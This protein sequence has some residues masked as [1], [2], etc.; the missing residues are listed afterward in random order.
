MIFFLT[1]RSWPCTPCD[2]SGA[3]LI[4][5]YGP[6]HT[7]LPRGIECELFVTLP[8]LH[9]SD[10]HKADYCRKVEWIC[11]RGFHPSGNKGIKPHSCSQRSDTREVK[12]GSI[13]T[14]LI[15]AEGWKV[16]QISR[17]KA[18]LK[19]GIWGQ[20]RGQDG[21]ERKLVPAQTSLL[22]SPAYIM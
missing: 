5:Q 3:L 21:M 7:H 2:T 4:V 13:R 15:S 12:E 16:Q 8:R 17:N 10:T 20:Y 14:A 1:Q 11:R 9:F 6:E 18:A 22:R 19:K